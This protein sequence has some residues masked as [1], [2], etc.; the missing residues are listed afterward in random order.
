MYPCRFLFCFFFPFL[1]AEH[2]FP[3]HWLPETHWSGWWA[4]AENILWET[5]GHGSCSW[6]S[7][8]GVEG[9]LCTK[10]RQ[11]YLSLNQKF[12]MSCSWHTRVCVVHL[13]GC[14]ESLSCFMY[15]LNLAIMLASSA[16]LIYPSA[17]KLC[18]Q[19]FL[20]FFCSIF[21]FSF[22]WFI[23]VQ[24]KLNADVCFSQVH[25]CFHCC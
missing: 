7:W 24:G 23:A 9:R 16:T 10:I 13:A 5:D 18:V 17:F 19:S 25:N 3:S 8:W 1:L 12:F 11:L 6:L 15:A 22:A 14:V 2:L 20:H 4:Q 21:S